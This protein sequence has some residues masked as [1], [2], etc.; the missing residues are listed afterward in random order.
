MAVT[1]GGSFVLM[2]KKSAKSCALR[3]KNQRNGYE[4]LK[5]TE[6]YVIMNA[7][8]ISESHLGYAYRVIAA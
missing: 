4:R 8:I 3:I 1:P 5:D 6:K 7:I 2:N